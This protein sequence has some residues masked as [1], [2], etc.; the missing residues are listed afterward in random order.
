MSV[1]VYTFTHLC[2]PQ[3]AAPYNTH[4][5]TRLTLDARLRIIFLDYSFD[6]FALE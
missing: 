5:S 4:A 6:L 1:Y 3:T 2:V